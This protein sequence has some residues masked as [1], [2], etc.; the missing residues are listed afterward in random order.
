MEY[1]NVFF[2]RVRGLFQALLVLLL[3]TLVNLPR[4]FE[5]ETRRVPTKDGGEAVLAGATTLR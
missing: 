3:A 5:F 2:Y 4:W 1:Y